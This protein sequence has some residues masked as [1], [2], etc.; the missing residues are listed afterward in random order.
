MDSETTDQILSFLDNHMISK[1]LNPE[2]TYD[3]KLILEKQNKLCSTIFN[4]LQYL[5]HNSKKSKLFQLLYFHPENHFIYFLLGVLFQIE[6]NYVE[7]KSFYNISLMYNKNHIDTYMQLSNLYRNISDNISLAILERAHQI[8]D[9]NLN[10]I[11]NMGVAYTELKMYDK[12]L[13]CFKKCCSTTPDVLFK[14][15][16]YGNMGTI[17]SQ[18]GRNIESID[19]LN[20]AEK[21]KLDFKNLQTKLYNINYLTENDRKECGLLD[22]YKEVIKINDVMTLK[23]LYKFDDTFNNSKIRIGYVSPDFKEHAVLKFI[24]NILKDHDRNRFEIFAYY[25]NKFNH[26]DK[27]SKDLKENIIGPSNF[28]IICDM[29]TK[30]A[31]DLIYNDKINILVD[32]GGHSAESRLDVF[33]CKPSPIQVSYLGYPATT[34]LYQID[35]RITDVIAD[36]INTTEKYTEELIRLPC[37]FLRYNNEHINTIHDIIN[38]SKRKDRDYIVLGLINKLNKN[39]DEFYDLVSKIMSIYTNTKVLIKVGSIENQDKNRSFYLDKLGISSDRL[40][41]YSYI[42][43]QKDYLDVFNKIDVLLD[44]FPYSGTTTTCDALLMNV[45]IITLYG[46]THCQNVSSSI[47]Y[48][49]YPELICYNKDEYVEKVGLLINNLDNYDDISD[50]FIKYMLCENNFMYHYE[51]LFENMLYKHSGSRVLTLNC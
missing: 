48:R 32:L 47:L 11:N 39:S 18:L 49:I 4:E 36:P 29:D 22:V 27:F 14:M 37:C 40:F 24:Y 10:I 44:T 21:I 13:E 43:T 17:L 19:Y 41:L 33:A 51:N 3:S 1:L 31:S 28:K 8:D 25:S 20:K 35:Y 26:L 9:T 30:Q 42:V 34:G 5:D 46:N 23:N 45:P 2:Y 12:G 6:G 15:K 16:T 38:I 7:A 50:R